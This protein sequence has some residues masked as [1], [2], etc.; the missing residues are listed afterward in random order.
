MWFSLAA[1][2]S[3]YVVFMTELDMW[4]S[5]AAGES[6]YVVSMTELDMWFSLAAGESFYA[7]CWSELGMGETWPAVYVGFQG[8]VWWRHGGLFM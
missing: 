5:L 8:R 7:V 6:F 3:F 1:G 2:E 4:F